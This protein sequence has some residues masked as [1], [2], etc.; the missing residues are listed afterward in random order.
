MK[1]EHEE[2][3]RVR[4]A[5]SANDMS[6]LGITFAELDYNQIETRRIVWQLLSHAR[7]E[8]EFDFSDGNLMV[9][10]F[11][12]PGGGCI[13][14]FTNIKLEEKAK[15]LKLKRSYFGPYIF[16]F[17]NAEYL[18]AASEQVSN[19]FENYILK[20]QL[21]LKDEKY[22]LAIYT[23][24]RLDDALRILLLEYGTQCGESAVAFLSEHA[25]LISSPGAIDQM[26]RAFS[27]G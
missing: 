24:T 5:L 14:Y 11:P 16:V 8:M 3:G 21:Y 27:R 6:E 17:E 26:G 18:I 20:S 4:I 10:A 22:Y 19:N 13:I 15:K 23:A 2:A 25:R 7:S 12:S 1:I 9:E